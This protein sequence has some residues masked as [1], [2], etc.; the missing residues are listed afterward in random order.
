MA[1]SGVFEIHSLEFPN[2]LHETY[3]LGSRKKELFRYFG[4]I[5]KLPFLA[6]SDQNLAISAVIHKHFEIFFVKYF[7]F[8]SKIN[9]KC[10]EKNPLFVLMTLCPYTKM[11][12]NKVLF[13]LFTQLCPTFL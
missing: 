9:N 1:K 7:E 3:S 8:F 4:K 2:F 12:Q 5:Q 6:K 10:F 13:G 11:G